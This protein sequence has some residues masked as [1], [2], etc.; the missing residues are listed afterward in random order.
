MSFESIESQMVILFV[1]IVLGY[2]ARKTRIMNDRFDAQFSKLLLN[3]T[4]PCLIIS[5]VLMNDNLPDAG[6]VGM[7]FLLSCASYAIILAIAFAVPFVLRFPKDKRGTYSFMIAF[8]NVGFIGF[9]VL[10]SIFGDGAILYA[11]IFNIPFNVLVFT[12]GVFMISEREGT[13]KERLADAAKHIVS[14]TLLACFAAMAL[15]LMRITE[16]GII[17][18]SLEVVG[19]MTTPAALLII[20]SALAKMP[21]RE[22][23][24]SAR[25]YIASVF[26]LAVVPVAVFFIFRM[27]VSDP[28]LLGTIV[29]TSGMPV[30]TNGTLLCLQ[31]GGDLKTMTKGTFISTVM[32][33]I[34]IP[35]V[36]MM[37]VY[38]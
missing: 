10:S 34:T 23:V 3:V 4:L 37:L 7:I 17:G 38:L 14:P 22:M 26:R 12:V 29:I 2:V 6:T 28:M 30:A 13:V 20:G 21:I 35:L 24:S 1:G 5:S 33:L 25:P 11:A 18:Q 15:A 32:S 27:F 9:P 8:G 16:S 19:Q 31:Y 36:A